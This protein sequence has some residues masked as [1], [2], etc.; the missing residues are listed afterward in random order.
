MAGD[1]LALAMRRELRAMDV[2]LEENDDE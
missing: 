1:E 2:R